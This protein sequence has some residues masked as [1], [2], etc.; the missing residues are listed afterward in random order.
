VGVGTSDQGERGEWGKGAGEGGESV[1][2]YERELGIGGFDRVGECSE[3]MLVRFDKVMGLI[4]DTICYVVQDN[5]K[6][7]DCPVDKAKAIKNET[8]IEGFRK[9]YLR[10]GAATVRRRGYSRRNRSS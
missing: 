7:I 4:S 1:G 10:D 8:E 9:A 3:R 6:T 5:V 2:S